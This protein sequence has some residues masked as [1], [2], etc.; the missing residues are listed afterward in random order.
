MKHFKC[1]VRHLI[2]NIIYYLDIPRITY[3]KNNN[4]IGT[5]IILGPS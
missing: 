1:I 4:Y 5:Q 3:Y 2:P